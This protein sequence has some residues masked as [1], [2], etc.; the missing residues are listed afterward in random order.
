MISL[1]NQPPIWQPVLPATQTLGVELGAKLVDQLL[2]IAV[3]KPCVLLTR[4]EAE[5]NGA[6]QGPGRILANVVVLGTVTQFDRAVLDRVEHLQAGY[7]F[8]GSE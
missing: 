6:E 3:I 2:A 1:L 7:D 5:R 8:A 4:I